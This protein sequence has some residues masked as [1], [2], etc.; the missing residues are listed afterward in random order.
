MVNEQEVTATSSNVNNPNRGR[1]PNHEIYAKNHMIISEIQPAPETSPS[2]SF[3]C[4]MGQESILTAKGIS[5]QPDGK[6]KQ[7]NLLEDGDRDQ[8]LNQSSYEDKDVNSEGHSITSTFE[9]SLTIARKPSD[10]EHESNMSI[11]NMNDTQPVQKK[12]GR[13][14]PR[15]QEKEVN[16][17]KEEESS[18]SSLNSVNSL[19]KEPLYEGYDNDTSKETSYSLM[20][21]CQEEKSCLPSLI[22]SP[23][24]PV[25][26]DLESSNI[27]PHLPNSHDGNVEN[28]RN[29]E[30]DMYH[31]TV[32]SAKTESLDISDHSNHCYVENSA[33][34]N[35]SS[36]RLRE[37][38]K[39]DRI[40]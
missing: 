32:L 18:R 39:L 14:R 20:S 10:T 27:Q 38:S 35:R 24:C 30:Q 26:N 28:L 25:A 12:R 2:S 19:D 29:A 21:V 37:R 36:T 17:L 40:E 13:G 7:I 31:T 1:P 34:K 11:S 15:K 16:I 9:D 5:P 33:S 23:A 6:I 8:M 3:S 22:L 4:S